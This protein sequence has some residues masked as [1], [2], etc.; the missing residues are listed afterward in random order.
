MPREINFKKASAYAS[1]TTGGDIP[2]QQFAATEGWS[3]NMTIPLYNLERDVT[4]HATALSDLLKPEPHTP[5]AL[6]WQWG[7]RKISPA[8]MT[9][10]DRTEFDWFSDG[11]VRG[12]NLQVALVEINPKS[13]VI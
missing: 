8:I 9:Q 12:C 10:C 4:D 6:I 11:R 1:T 3:V 7:N 2:L 5:P 13:L